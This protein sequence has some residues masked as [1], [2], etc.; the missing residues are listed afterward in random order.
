MAVFESA[1]LDED[2]ELAGHFRATLWVSSTSPDADFYVA[3]RVMDGE[4]EI[5]Y[6]T[7]DAASVAPLTWGCLKASHRVLDPVRSTTERPWHTHRREDARPLRPDEVVKVDVEM[8]VA[9]G[10]IAAGHR[11]RIEIS[12][13]EGRGTNPD[14]QRAYDDS[15]H[16]KAVNRIFT[17]GALPSSITI[18]VVPRHSR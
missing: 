1:P 8:L 9:T 7:R 14:W 10:R 16:R 11:L 13:A 12:P 5:L 17:G 3:L 15:Y 6:Q 18:P 2:V 4:R